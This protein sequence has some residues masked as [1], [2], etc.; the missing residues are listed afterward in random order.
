MKILV[1]ASC[2]NAVSSNYHVEVKRDGKVYSTTF[3]KGIITEHTRETGVCKAD[4]HGTTTTFTLDDDIWTEDVLDLHRIDRRCR[5]LAYLNP[6]LVM[7]VYFDT[8]D[9]NGNTV[10]KQEQYCYPEGVKAYVEKLTKGKVALVE[11]ELITNSVE[12]EESG[13]VDV[14]VGFA[15][16]DSYNSDIKGFVNNINTEYGGDHVTGVKEGIAKAITRYATEEN[17]VKNSSDIKQNDVLEGLTAIVSVTVADPNY[18]GQGKNNL[19]MKEVRTACRETVSDY[20]FDYLSRDVN[21]AKIIIEKALAAAK[22]RAAAKKARDAARGITKAANS[23]SL[24]EKFA[25]CS[26]N[27]PEESEVFLVEGKQNCSR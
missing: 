10:Q 27:D 7:V 1:G 18:E 9:A 3:E 13:V 25:N 17:L 6:G 12:T 2:V 19:R 20:L 26:S 4:E 5:Q 8:V 16:T 21:R 22:A 15:Y 11:P 14:A 24:P 23:G